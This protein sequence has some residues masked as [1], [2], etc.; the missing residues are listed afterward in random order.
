M[1]VKWQDVR[2]GKIR[3]KTEDRGRGQITEGLVRVRGATENFSR[4]GTGS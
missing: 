2:L 3:N 4:R 1:E